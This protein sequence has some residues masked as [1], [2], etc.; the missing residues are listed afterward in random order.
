MKALVLALVLFGGSSLPE[1]QW[2]NWLWLYTLPQ[3]PDACQ[4]QYGG[5]GY[6]Q[7]DLARCTWMI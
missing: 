1:R 2:E 4:G 6:Q 7:R 5:H 3:T